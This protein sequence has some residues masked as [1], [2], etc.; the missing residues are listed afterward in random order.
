MEVGVY[1]VELEFCYSYDVK[2]GWVKSA[3]DEYIIVRQNGITQGVILISDI[4]KIA[5]LFLLR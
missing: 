3:W 4:L 5:F 1:L 2:K